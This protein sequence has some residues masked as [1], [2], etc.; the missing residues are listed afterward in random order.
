[1]TEEQ[2][3]KLIL[4]S[5]LAHSTEHHSEAK[6]VIAKSIKLVTKLSKAGSVKSEAKAANARLNGLKGG[7]PKKIK[8]EG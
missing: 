1:M 7:R 2:L 5:F 8:I 6:A 3:L 4:K